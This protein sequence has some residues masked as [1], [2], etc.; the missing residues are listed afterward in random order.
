[1]VAALVVVAVAA[2]VAPVDEASPR[3]LSSSGGDPTF[4]VLV[5]SWGI[6]IGVRVS[7]VYV[8]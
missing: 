7:I 5:H 6:G 3:H 4:M 8:L 2:A 1:M